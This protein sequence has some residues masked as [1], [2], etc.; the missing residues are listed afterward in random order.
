MMAGTQ[1]WYI[2][3]DNGGNS[4][5]TLYAYAYDG[6]LRWQKEGIYKLFAIGP[7]D[8]VYV[9]T[10]NYTITALKNDGSF[11]WET[12]HNTNNNYP[13]IRINK[14]GNLYLYFYLN[15]TVVGI[16]HEGS[17]SWTTS[18]NDGGG[19]CRSTSVTGIFPN[20]DLFA[21]CYYNGYRITSDGIV[22]WKAH[23]SWSQIFMVLVSGVDD[24]ICL[25]YYQNELL[26]IDGALDTNETIST[27]HPVNSLIGLTQNGDIVYASDGMLVI[28]GVE[29]LEVPISFSNAFLA[30]DGSI[31][32]L[33]GSSTANYTM[34]VIAD[35]NGGPA[36][37][38]WPHPNGDSGLTNRA[39]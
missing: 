14:D 39:P 19:S 13:A 2:F 26:R 6:S 20:G 4:P 15:K 11:L 24:L 35:D 16:D 18:I 33:S 25:N 37:T 8:A 27:A 34:T 31:V 29:V 3:P 10:S 32:L 22:T 12:A 5:Q 7:N 1:G 23:Y 21:P 28:E 9:R 17:L 36:T 38:G 30:R